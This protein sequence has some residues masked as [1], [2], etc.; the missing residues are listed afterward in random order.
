M[1]I[2]LSLELLIKL[3][4]RTI[5]YLPSVSPNLFW[6]ISIVVNRGLSLLI[7]KEEFWVKIDTSSKSFIF[8]K[9][10]YYLYKY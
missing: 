4:S 6:L 7:V 1:D 5:L 9:L 3:D 10:I 2:V 8:S